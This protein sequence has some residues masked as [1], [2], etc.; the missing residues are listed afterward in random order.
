MFELVLGVLIVVYGLKL[1][2]A[3]GKKVLKKD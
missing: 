3:G 1:I 2:I